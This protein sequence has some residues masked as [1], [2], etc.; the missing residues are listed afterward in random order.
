MNSDFITHRK[1]KPLPP[2]VLFPWLSVGAARSA[3]IIS[4]HSRTMDS[5]MGKG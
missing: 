5:L 3:V 4:N 1:K 2:F